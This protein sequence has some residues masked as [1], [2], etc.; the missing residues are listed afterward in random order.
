MKRL[1]DS[2]LEELSTVVF[3]M[4]ELA[5]E[6]IDESI[7]GFLEGMDVSTR[8]RSLAEIIVTMGVDAEDKAFELIAKYQPVAS[9]LRIIKSYMKIAY[10]LERFG[11]YAWDI[12]FIHKKLAKSEKCIHFGDLLEKITEKV[13][14]MVRTSIGALKNHDAESARTLAKTEQEVD[15]VYF[16]YLDQLAKAHPATEC[17]T[18]N[19]LVVTYLERISDHAAYLGESVIYIA[20]GEKVILR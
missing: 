8:V 11:R 16:R 10:D 7:A 5:E 6:A 4:G 17:L 12:S 15:D 13:T 19:L 18:S 1:L 14:A 2:G 3:R 9:D 20:T